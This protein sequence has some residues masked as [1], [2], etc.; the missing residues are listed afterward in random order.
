MKYTQVPYVCRD[1]CTPKNIKTDIDNT[2]KK[3]KKER[4]KNEKKRGLLHHA[5]SFEKKPTAGTHLCHPPIPCQT[6]LHLIPT[7][8]H[9]HSPRFLSKTSCADVHNSQGHCW[10]ETTTQ[11]LFRHRFSFWSGTQRCLV[12]SNGAMPKSFDCPTQSKPTCCHRG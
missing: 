6:V 8:L 12:L 2:C 10:C 11:T 9:L 5:I 7:H 3:P 1:D 4:E